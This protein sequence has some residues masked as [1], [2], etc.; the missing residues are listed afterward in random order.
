MSTTKQRK[1]F[2]LRHNETLGNV[3]FHWINSRL[4]RYNSTVVHH[5]S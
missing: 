4:L 3:I 1:R 5:K 2:N